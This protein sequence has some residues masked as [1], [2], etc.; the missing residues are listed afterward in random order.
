MSS[1]IYFSENDKRSMSFHVIRI[2]SNILNKIMPNIAINQAEKLLLIPAKS[3]KEVIIPNAM[4]IE[5][6]KGE[7]GDLQQYKLGDGPIVLLAHGWSGSAS[8]F[9]GLMELI[10]Q[11]GYQ[12]IAFDHY[13]HA[14]SSGKVAHLPLFIRGINDLVSLHGQDNIHCVVS[15]SMGTVAA[16]NLPKNISHLLIAPVFG[17]YDS[18][19]KSVFDSGMSPDLFER[20]LQ[21]IENDFDIKFTDAVSEQHIGLVERP[22]NIVHDI[23]DRFASFIGSETMA[24]QH[25]NIVLHQTKGQ[26][27]GRIINSDTTW[28]VLSR[29]LDAK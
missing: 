19:R 9:F 6:I 14:K 21:K 20:L 16:L 28:Q 26:G 5:K 27:H 18:L 10:A 29:L 7:E 22:V 25:P 23:N 13:G 12:A 15:H 3:K 2:I 8:Q 1:K 17:F 4:I 24:K 11:S